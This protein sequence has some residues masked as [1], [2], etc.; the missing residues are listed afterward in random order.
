MK[1]NKTRFANKVSWAFLKLL[2]DR[3]STLVLII[4]L[5]ECPW[6][7]NIHPYNFQHFLNNILC[8]GAKHA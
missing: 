7:I 2:V 6:L 1:E 5:N 4:I 3:R 8:C